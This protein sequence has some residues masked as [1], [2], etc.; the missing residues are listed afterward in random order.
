MPAVV[1]V[2]STRNVNS[3]YN[4]CRTW[5]GD[6][7]AEPVDGEGVDNTVVFDKRRLEEHR[8]DIHRMLHELPAAATNNRGIYSH[9]ALVNNEGE[10]W[11]IHPGTAELLLMMGNALEEVEYLGKSDVYTRDWER[12]M[13][14]IFFINLFIPDHDPDNTRRFRVTSKP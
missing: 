9:Q 12:A 2:L 11:T 5:S 1:S 14:I 13:R 8:S 6:Q 7:S 3:V 10:A 4:Y